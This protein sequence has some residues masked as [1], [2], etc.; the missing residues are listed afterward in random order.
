[1]VPMIADFGLSREVVTGEEYSS[2]GA[3]SLPLKWMVC[4]EEKH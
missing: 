1:M 2:T 3:D 4:L